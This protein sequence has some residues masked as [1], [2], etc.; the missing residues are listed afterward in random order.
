MTG[1]LRPGD[2]VEVRSPAEIL[3]TL[4]ANGTLGNVPFMP[5]MIGFCGRRFHV[6]RRA[7]KT[8]I[9]GTGPSSM[10]AFHSGEF[11]LLDGLRCSGG[12]HDGCQKACTIL[13]HGTWLRPVAGS[14]PSTTAESADCKLLRD[15]LKTSAGSGKHFCQA[16]ELLT[17]TAHL[18]QW[19]RL[20]TCLTDVRAGNSTGLEMVRMIG[21]WLFWKIRSAVFGRFPRGPF[22]RTPVAALDLRAGEIVEV[23]SIEHIVNSLDAGGRNRGLS[24]TPDM[25]SLCGTRQ[26]VKQRIDKLIVDG[27]G[28]MRRLQN[29][30][31]LEGSYCGCSHVAFG[32]C[33]RGEF[34]YWRE[35]WLHR[36][37][38][39]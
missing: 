16:S 35:A 18:S 37:S 38:G 10:R 14:E 21:I 12:D 8:C 4:D 3:S 7:V 9:S 11:F 36:P 22:R 23:N 17:A 19:E 32:G 5:E 6:S 27:T 34:A 39:T 2:I 29:T 13:W 33:P 15:R 1:R 25:I 30:V 28:E 24:F 26:R 20:T 31:Y